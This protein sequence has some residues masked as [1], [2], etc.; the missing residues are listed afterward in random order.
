MRFPAIAYRYARTLW[1]LSVSDTEKAEIESD[2]LRLKEIFEKIPGL[3]ARCRSG[4]DGR[5]TAEEL[6]RLAFVPY[7]GERLGKLLRLMASNNRYGAIPFLPSAW[8]DLALSHSEIV[9]VKMEYASNPSEE[10]LE[11]LKK[12]ME[13]RLER[14]VRFKL[15]SVPSLM[16]G[17]R[18]SW[19]NR[20]IDASLAGR[21]RVLRQALTHS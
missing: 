18:L 13:K 14:A 2:M 5:K 1:E 7:V 3:E 17:F 20:L 8:E 4:R 21:V 6:V 12:M 16:G 9:T 19:N 15:L 10:L 11:T